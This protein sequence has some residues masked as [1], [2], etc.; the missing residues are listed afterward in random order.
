MNV[1]LHVQKGMEYV[2]AT[3]K[4]TAK[5]EKISLSALVTKAVMLYCTRNN[6]MLK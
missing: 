4:A 6:V 3:A 2:W 1:N 5:N